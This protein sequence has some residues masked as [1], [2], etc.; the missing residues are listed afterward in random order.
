M[1]YYAH[2]RLPRRLIMLLM[3]SSHQC[4]RLGTLTLFFLYTI[5]V[6]RMHSVYV[7]ALGE[8]NAAM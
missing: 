4:C 8:C 3:Q 2:L 7:E 1:V 5:F 6:Y